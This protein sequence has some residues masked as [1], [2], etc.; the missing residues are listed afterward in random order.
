MLHTEGCMFYAPEHSIKDASK[1]WP[2]YAYLPLLPR[3]WVEKTTPDQKRKFPFSFRFTGET[4]PQESFKI[5]INGPYSIWRTNTQYS[6]A[7]EETT[8][9]FQ[10]AGI[11]GN[12]S[13]IRPG[14]RIRIQT[15]I[16]LFHFYEHNKLPEITSIYRY[17]QSV[18]RNPDVSYYC[19]INA[20]AIYGYADDLLSWLMGVNDNYQVTLYE[21]P[22]QKFAASNPYKDITQVYADGRW[23]IAEKKD[24][25]ITTTLVSG[26]Y[27][28]FPRS[29][30]DDLIKNYDQFIAMSRRIF[31]VLGIDPQA[32]TYVDNR[33]MTDLGRT[34][35]VKNFQNVIAKPS[36][37]PWP[38]PSQEK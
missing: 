10:Q 19:G 3:D 16:C 26:S 23:D 21:R 1:N 20:H 17:I 27:M 31:P 15:A 4:P 18:N 29:S 28:G 12:E 2:I 5:E 7:T 11:V 9:M 25:E 34:L 22:G 36:E 33:K 35:A 38:Q 30:H 37:D 14:D 32:G 24:N 13:L 8:M 6:V